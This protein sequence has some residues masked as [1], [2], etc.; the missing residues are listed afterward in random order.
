MEEKEDLLKKYE[1]LSKDG[2]IIEIINLENQLDISRQQIF[3]LEERIIDVNHEI[4]FLRQV[5]LNLTKK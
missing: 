2:L 1:N 4:D 5:I 3:Q